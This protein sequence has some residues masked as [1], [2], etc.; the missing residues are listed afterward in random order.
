MGLENPYFRTKHES[1]GIVRQKCSLPW[2]IY[3]P[4]IVVGNSETGSKSTRLTALTIFS[5]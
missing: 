3:R 2:R 4:G 5:N 1:E